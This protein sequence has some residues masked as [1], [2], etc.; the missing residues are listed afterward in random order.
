MYQRCPSKEER[1]SILP[2]TGAGRK[3]INSAC[4]W[5]REGYWDRKDHTDLFLQQ[6]LSSLFQVPKIDIKG[7]G[8]SPGE[9]GK[10]SEA[11]HPE[12]DP[13]IQGALLLGTQKDDRVLEIGCKL[14]ESLH[15]KELVRF[16]PLPTH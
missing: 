2:V 13:S 5:G 9:K 16:S 8:G 4:D 6:I 7:W 3:G 10:G 15:L 14:I 1:E 11:Q 12:C